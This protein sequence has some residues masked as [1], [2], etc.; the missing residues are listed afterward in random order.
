MGFKDVNLI[1]KAQQIVLT[2]INGYKSQC[3]NAIINSTED[4][5]KNYNKSISYD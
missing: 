4:K 2:Y 3:S 5:V 1:L